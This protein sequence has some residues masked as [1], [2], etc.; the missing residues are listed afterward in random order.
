MARNFKTVEDLNRYLQS[1]IVE[2]LERDVAP[3]IKNVQSTA[4]ESEVYAVYTSQSTSKYRYKRRGQAGGLSDTNNM[5]DYLTTTPTGAKMTIVN[6]AKSEDGTFNVAELVEAGH[7]G[8]SGH[9]YQYTYTEAGNEDD[10]LQARPFQKVTAERLN[11]S[12][13]HV[14]ALKQGLS[15]SVRVK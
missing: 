13:E 10:Y 7:E 5:K 2:S 3:V 6:E 1:K 14:T 4:V 9:K 8:N 11:A 15:R 12:K